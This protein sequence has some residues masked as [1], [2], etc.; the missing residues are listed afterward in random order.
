[1]EADVDVEDERED[2]NVDEGR[3]VVAEHVV[4]PGAEVAEDSESDCCGTGIDKLAD[5]GSQ[6]VVDGGKESENAK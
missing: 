1:M 5:D 6:E 4:K 3:E 2:N